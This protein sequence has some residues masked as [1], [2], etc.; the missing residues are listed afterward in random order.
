MWQVP[1]FLL[2]LGPIYSVLFAANGFCFAWALSELVT[3][4]RR[5]KEL[6]RNHLDE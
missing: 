3:A 2:F 4:L 6:H 5:R 1:I